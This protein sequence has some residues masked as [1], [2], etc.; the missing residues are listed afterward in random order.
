MKESSS[1]NPEHFKKK[2]RVRIGSKNYDKE[3]LNKMIANA[4]RASLKNNQDKI[5]NKNF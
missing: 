2:E 5:L 4:K 3:E 1:P